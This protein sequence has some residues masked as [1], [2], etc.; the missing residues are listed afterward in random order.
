MSYGTY[1]TKRPADV[2][3]S[4]IEVLLVYSSN[5]N[6]I[7]NQTVIKFN[8]ED[9][10]TPIYHNDNTGGSTVEILGGLYNLT[11]PAENIQNKGFYTV[12]IRPAQIR[13]TIADCGSLSTFSDVKGLVFDT[14]NAPEGFVDKFQNNGLNGFRIEYLNDDGT[15]IQSTS[16]IITSSFLCEP[17]SE[18]SANT[19]QKTVRYL[20]S[21][22]GSLLFCTVTPNIA[23]SFKPDATPFIGLKGQSVIITSTDFNPIVMEIEMVDYDMES[24]AIALYG[25][26]TKSMDDGIYT[27][28]DFDGNIYRQYDLY[29]VRNSTGEKLY[30]VRKKREDDNIDTSKNLNNIG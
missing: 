14:N 5:R 13:T 19:S 1:G 23:P 9:V 30:E 20:Y 21:N 16:R 28:Y 24:L 6:E 18:N 2:N 8:G 27:L 25:D 22:S 11:L 12:Y 17:I 4:D 7:T 15:K 3:P 10:I 29:E 26:Q